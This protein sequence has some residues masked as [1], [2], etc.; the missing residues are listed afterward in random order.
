MHVIKRIDYYR[1]T[2]QA[3][4]MTFQFSTIFSFDFSNT[5]VRKLQGKLKR[6]HVI[7]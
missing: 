5:L 1:K 2:E 7:V 4:V 3:L 6:S